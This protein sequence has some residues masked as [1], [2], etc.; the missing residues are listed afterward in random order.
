M[1]NASTEKLSVHH[2]IM[3]A[4]RWDLRQSE[5]NLLT[6]CDACHNGY[7]TVLERDGKIQQAEQE[8]QEVKD[9]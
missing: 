4:K 6:L 1:T 9:R 3:V 7:F 8:A 2:I 5:S